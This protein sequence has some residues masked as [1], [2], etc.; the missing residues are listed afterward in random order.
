MTIFQ[1]AYAS[2][3]MGV[4]CIVQSVTLTGDIS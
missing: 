4:L 2:V 3:I 1:R